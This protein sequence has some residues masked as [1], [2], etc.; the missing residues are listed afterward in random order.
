M[1]W[2]GDLP[3]EEPEKCLSH[4]NVFHRAHRCVFLIFQY[5]F[6]NGKKEERQMFKNGFFWLNVDKMKVFALNSSG[7]VS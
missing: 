6:P 1:K 4:M 5:M 3:N 7:F 2:K